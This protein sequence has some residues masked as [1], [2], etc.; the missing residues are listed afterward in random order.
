MESSDSPHWTA[1]GRILGAAAFFDAGSLQAWSGDFAKARRLLEHA[2]TLL[3][4]IAPKSLGYEAERLEYYHYWDWRQLGAVTLGAATLDP[5]QK[6][7][8]LLDG[9]RAN[10][11]AVATHLVLADAVEAVWRM[12]P[13]Q[14]TM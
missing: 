6:V 11:A 2:G 3:E 9:L 14:V 1:R 12:R 4:R 5:P 7:L 8:P 13:L 10:P